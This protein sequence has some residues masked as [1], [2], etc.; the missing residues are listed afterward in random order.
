[1]LGNDGLVYVCDRPDDRIQVFQK[2]CA[3]PSTSSNPQ[4]FC[5]PVRVIN[6]DQFPTATA[7]NRN[8]IL[9]AG[10]RGDD[11][12]FWP[13]IDYLAKQESDESKAHHRCRSRQR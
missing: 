4:P 7:A 1:V 10:T 11:M 9:L 2:T 3:V 12:Y 6:I 5:A 8:A 13:N